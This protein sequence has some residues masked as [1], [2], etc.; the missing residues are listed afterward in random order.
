VNSHTIDN[1]N[2]KRRWWLQMESIL[3]LFFEFARDLGGLIPVYHIGSRK[4]N[5]ICCRRRK[6]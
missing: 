1:K 3:V 6:R 4:K 2:E 5:V